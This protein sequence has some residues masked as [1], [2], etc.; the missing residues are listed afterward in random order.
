MDFGI[1][2]ASVHGISQARI[3]EWVAI[4]FSRGSFWLRD[5]T[6]VSYIEGK[7]FPVWT[8][9]EA[10]PA[11]VA[12][13]IAQLGLAWL[14]TIC[15]WGLGTTHS[16]YSKWVTKVCLSVFVERLSLRSWSVTAQGHLGMNMGSGGPSHSRLKQGFGSQPETEVGL[17]QWKHPNLS[18]RTVSD[19]ALA[20]QIC[21]K[22]FPQK[23]SGEKSQVF[24]RKEKDYRR[25]G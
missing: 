18:P 3:P 11:S 2:W 21:R 10:Q 1:P 16:N 5:Q 4:S 12:I 23:K 24:I 15:L 17:Q 13:K 22:E 6:W 25:C 19:K 9:R 14:G 20:L 7:V 8:T